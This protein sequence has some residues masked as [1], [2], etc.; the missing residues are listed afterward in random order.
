MFMVCSFLMWRAVAVAHDQPVLV[1]GL[2]EPQEGQAQVLDRLEPAEPEQILLQGKDERLVAAVTL[3]ARTKAGELRA[4]RKR[5]SRWKSALMYS[6]MALF[7]TPSVAS[8]S[9]ETV[10]LA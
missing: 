6:A 10:H 9:A 5:I 2:L 3:R 8:R 7:V 4:P 1:V